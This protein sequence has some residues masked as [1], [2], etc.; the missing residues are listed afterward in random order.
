MGHLEPECSLPEKYIVYVDESGDHGLGDNI[1]N[2]YP[3]FVLAFCIFSIS[4][5]TQNI[6]P[7]ILNF[8]FKYFGHDMVVLHEREIRKSE[9]PFDILMD[10]VVR[11]EFVVDL[12]SIVT[13]SKFHIVSATVNKEDFKRNKETTIL[14]LYHLAMKSC[15]EEL[16]HFLSDRNVLNRTFIVFEERGKNE[17]RDLEL[18]FRRVKDEVFMSGRDCEIMFASKKVN[19][20]GLQMADLVARPIGRHLL[21]P[22]QSN[23]AFETLKPKMFSTPIVI[24]H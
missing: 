5:Y 13:D 15:L 8:K 20:C 17:D 7:T 11:E 10:R 22:D 19:S 24:D 14:N 4:E 2:S 9:K 3:M 12:S 21:N 16:V 18:E 1:D 6:V 23:R